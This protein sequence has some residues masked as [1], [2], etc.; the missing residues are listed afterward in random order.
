MNEVKT[1]FGYVYLSV[2]LEKEGN[3]K[4][5]RGKRGMEKSSSAECV[6]MNIIPEFV[7]TFTQL[8]KKY[9]FSFH[10]LHII[11]QLIIQHCLK[12]YSSLLL[13]FEVMVCPGCCQQYLQRMFKAVVSQCLFLSLF[14]CEMPI[15]DLY[16]HLLDV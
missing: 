7:R 4:H 16:K 11:L 9:V 8:N 1:E 13:T 10:K 15:I 3:D 14:I 6:I 2:T 12:L 5:L